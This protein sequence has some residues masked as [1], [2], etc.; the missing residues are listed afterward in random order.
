LPLVTTEHNEAALSP[1]N[2]PQIADHQ[3]CSASS[4]DVSEQQEP[5]FRKRDM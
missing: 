1:A 5:I 2:L 4:I 3:T